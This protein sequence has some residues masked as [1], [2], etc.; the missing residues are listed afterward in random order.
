MVHEQ[1]IADIRYH[2]RNRNFA[3]ETRKALN[4]GLGAF[5]RIYLGWSKALPKNERDAIAARAAELE[6]I[7]DL[8]FKGKPV[9]KPEDFLPIEEIIVGAVMAR[10][11]FDKIEKD[12]T[13][14]MEKLAREL[15]VWVWA[16][17][18]RGF[19]ARS[20]AVI[21]AETG[22]LSNYANP[23]KVWK[24]MGLAVMGD[25]RQGGLPKSA[26]KKAWI[27][28]GYSRLRRSRMWNIGDALVKGNADGVYRR[29]YLTRKEYE[30]NKADAEGLIVAPSA[31]IPKGKASEYRSVGHIHRRAQRVMEKRLLRDLWNVWRGRPIGDAELEK[32]A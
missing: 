12:A 29:L 19:G 13:K 9:E 1:L 7:G 4:N 18:V 15:S 16:E 27:E 5:I 21:I 28:H 8:V 10:S 24:R 14:A 26:S 2:H 17:S 25:V 22:D 20:L 23:A 32:A 11:P 31:K 6:K 30:V 3:M